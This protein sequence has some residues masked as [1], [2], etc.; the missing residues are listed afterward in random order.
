MKNVPPNGYEGWY[1]IRTHE[2]DAQQRLTIP[3]LMTLMQEAS[4]HNAREL[5]ISLWDEEMNNLSWVILRKELN[6]V[7]MPTLGDKVKVVTYPAGFQKIFAYRDFRVFDEEGNELATAG[8]TWTLMNLNER[9]MGRIPEHILNLETLQPENCLTIPQTRLKM[10]SALKEKYTYTIRHFDLDWNNH[11][12]N[13][14]LAKLMIQSVDIE[15]MSSRQIKKFT[16]HIKSECYLND[17][18]KV[19]MSIKGNQRFHQISDTKDKA[20]AMSISEWT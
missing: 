10:D 4:M 8:S 3:A 20:I 6:I 17:S 19:L 2:V 12:N 9:R 1:T 11:V 15:L 14:V 18:L 5:Q 13:I 7:K 16:I